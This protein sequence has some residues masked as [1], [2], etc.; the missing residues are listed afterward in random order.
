M[1]KMKTMY[2]EDGSFYLE[3][4]GP[5]NKDGS[6]RRSPKRTFLMEDVRANALGVMG[7]LKSLTQ[8]QR[9][10]VLEHSLKINKV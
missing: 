10:R 7:L 3:N 5:I 6:L 8:E 1:S 4:T 2:R 9:K